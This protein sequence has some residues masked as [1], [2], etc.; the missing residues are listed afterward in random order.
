MNEAIQELKDLITH[1]LDV[2]EF[3]DILD[4]SLPELVELLEEQVEEHYTQLLDAC[5]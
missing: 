4:L 3:L 1:N 5:G 2:I